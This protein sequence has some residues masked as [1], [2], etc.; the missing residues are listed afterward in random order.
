MASINWDEFFMM[1]AV[2]ASCRSKDP[3]T[4]V[5]CVIVN[6]NNR[7]ISSGYNGFPNGIGDDKLP[8]TKDSECFDKTKYAYVVHAEVNSILN[9]YTTDLK[10]CI[11][12][13]TLFP[14]NE[15]TKL[16]IQKGIS[17]I[18]YAKMSNKH[19]PSVDASIKML[20]LV[21]IEISKYSGLDSIL[22]QLV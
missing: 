12:Y 20:N 10:D 19:K 1:S 15:C 4:R 11:L 6:R 17:K 21:N 18:I 7:I 3:N 13:T 5:G 9:S 2:L 8:W 16:I 14:C 22:L